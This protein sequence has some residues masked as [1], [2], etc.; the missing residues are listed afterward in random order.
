M[1]EVLSH[2]VCPVFTYKDCT[3]L[4]C[5]HRLSHTLVVGKGETWIFFIFNIIKIN[6]PKWSL[7]YE[8][9][10]FVLVCVFRSCGSTG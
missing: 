1:L 6:L 5:S 4:K 9:G 7:S 10:Y 2:E 3:E 8:T